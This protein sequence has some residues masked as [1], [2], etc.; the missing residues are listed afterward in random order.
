MG[1]H[2]YTFSTEW[3]NFKTG[4]YGDTSEKQKKS[5][6]K[7]INEHSLSHSHK[8]A[9]DIVKKQGEKALESSL[10]KTQGDILASTHIVF[11]TAYYIA[12][13]NGPYSNYP[14]LIDLQMINGV[15]VGRVLHSNVT[16][17]DIVHFIAKEMRQALLAS[18]RATRAK[19]TVIVDESTTLSKKSCLIVYLRTS[20]NSSEPLTFFLDLLELESTTNQ[21]P[22]ETWS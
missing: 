8:L 20:V 3:Q 16:C 21:L 15:N 9:E 1:K 4:P 18:I 14:G 2:R 19:L 12:K 10:L 13:N 7:K 17:A 11:K 6:R 5:L 22:A